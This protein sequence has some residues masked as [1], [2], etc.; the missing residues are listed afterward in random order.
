MVTKKKSMDVE[1]GEPD[2]EE[3]EQETEPNDEDPKVR[4]EEEKKKQAHADM[5]A[6]L[7][8]WAHPL[9]V[10]PKSMP[11]EGLLNVDPDEGAARIYDNYVMNYL[12]RS[13]KNYYPLRVKDD[14]EGYFQEMIH[15]RGGR[16]DLDGIA[17]YCPGPGQELLKPTLAQIRPWWEMRAKADEHAP[18]I[19]QCAHRE[20]KDMPMIID[21]ACQLEKVLE[22]LVKAGFN[23]DKLLDFK[24]SKDDQLEVTR[25][26]RM[27][28]VIRNVL[29]RA[30][31]GALPDKESYS[32][33][34]EDD[35][36]GGTSL[37]LPAL[38]I[39]L[40]NREKFRPMEATICASQCGIVLT[41]SLQL[42]MDYAWAFAD[43]RA[44]KGD[45]SR[46]ARMVPSM[47]EAGRS[48]ARQ[49]AGQMPRSAIEAV[50]MRSK[51]QWLNQHLLHLRQGTPERKLHHDHQLLL[52]PK[53]RRKQERKEDEGR[54]TPLRGSSCS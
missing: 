49:A 7:P 47:T 14:P 20:L 39:I 16:L 10:G 18:E 22:F 32:Y 51:S 54:A 43:E 33:F 12:I 8:E 48:D 29:Q 21:V 3:D 24:P 45:H 46:M 40:V 26:E 30:L 25:R 6:R 52:N 9:E 50:H 41:K 27:Q 37:R 19:Q 28:L 42:R 1:M 15:N 35:G 13:M 5:M 36:F 17:P 23:H 31:K 38:G 2:Q 53:P 34:R 44:K 11:T 4:E